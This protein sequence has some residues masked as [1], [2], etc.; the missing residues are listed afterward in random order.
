M[1]EDLAMLFS[2]AFD[3]LIADTISFAAAPPD[4]PPSLP[5]VF[6][7]FF[8]SSTFSGSF[9]GSGGGLRLLRGSGWGGACKECEEDS[10]FSSAFFLKNR[11]GGISTPLFY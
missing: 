4:A 2:D 10:F 7:D 3:A 11:N 9:S 6:S 8:S 5:A 1:A